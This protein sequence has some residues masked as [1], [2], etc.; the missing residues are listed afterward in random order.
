MKAL[1]LLFIGVISINQLQ[2]NGNKLFGKWVIY[3][4]VDGSITGLGEVEKESYINM[5][6]DLQS[7]YAYINGK[8]LLNPKY[9]CRNENAFDYLFYN[10]KINKELVGIKNDTL[11][12]IDV[13]ESNHV[14]Y[15][16]LHFEGELVLNIDG[17]FF[18]LK[19]KPV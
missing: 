5:E 17:V 6:F 19:K 9:N 11:K 12:V 1:I 18:F 13:S 10:Y 3:K 16:F 14:S 8:K 15:E 4:Y 2:A 7:D